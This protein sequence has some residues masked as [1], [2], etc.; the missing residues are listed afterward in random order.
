MGMTAQRPGGDAAVVRLHGGKKALAMVVDCTPRYCMADPER[1]GAQAVAETW[2]NLTAVGATPIAITD[3][4]NFGNPERPEI[5]GQFAGCVEGMRA[6]CLA[7]D[8]PVVSGNVSLYNETNGSGIWPTPVIGG[9]G[10]LEDVGKSMSLALK[11]AGETLILIG[12]TKGHL[13]ASLTLPSGLPPHAA[14]F[15]EDQGRYVL[16]TADP[17]GVLA[18]ATAAGIPALSIGVTG[19]DAL[20]VTGAGAISTGELKRIHEA[21]LPDYM[22]AP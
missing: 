15:G 17:Q 2:R 10:L 5:M 19:G 20:T 14:A 12:E 3:N 7:L 11:R 22:A 8:Y 9:V 13:G 18:R 4:M 1:G 21:W 16:A 6:A